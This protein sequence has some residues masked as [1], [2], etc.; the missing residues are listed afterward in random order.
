MRDMTRRD[1]NPT[2]TISSCR[3]TSISGYSSGDGH[4]RKS[5]FLSFMFML[6][7]TGKKELEVPSYYLELLH[8]LKVRIFRVNVIGKI[9]TMLN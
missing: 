3:C 5:L 4:R 7:A 9:I 8:N 6:K 1:A 2:R